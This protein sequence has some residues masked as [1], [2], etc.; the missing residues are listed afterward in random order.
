MRDPRVCA[1][2]G[3]TRGRDGRK[4]WGGGSKW[5]VA[6]RETRRGSR[7]RPSELGPPRPRLSLPIFPGAHGEAHPSR[8]KHG[9][10]T[11]W[12][13][14]PGPC[15]SRRERCGR[16][17]VPV[18]GAPCSH[19]SPPSGA[20]CRS[21][22][23]GCPAAAHP[24]RAGSAWPRTLDKTPAPLHSHCPLSCCLGLLLNSY[25]RPRTRRAPGG[26]SSDAGGWGAPQVRPAHHTTVPRAA[27][28]GQADPHQPPEHPN[29]EGVLS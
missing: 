15:P 25:P 3:G 22:G 10:G 11:S 1:Q 13:L 27:Q 24:L 4:P 7:V 5:T 16:G 26:P 8:G 19:S 17:L 23:G 20:A 18:A 2:P 12:G 21:W 6:A 29:G 9:P 14:L 28:A